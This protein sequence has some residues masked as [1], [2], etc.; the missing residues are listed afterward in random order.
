MARRR[1]AAASTAASAA[2]PAISTSVTH[3]ASPV[4]FKR[5][6]I[7][8]AF[9]R[10]ACSTLNTTS[11]VVSPLEFTRS[12]TASSIAAPGY[13]AATPS[14]SARAA[15]YFSSPTKVL[16]ER[17]VYTEAESSNM[18]SDS[19]MAASASATAHTISPMRFLRRAAASL[20]E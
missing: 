20:G 10:T 8:Q 16:G 2:Q 12:V 9:T 18:G 13:P 5:E 6:S 11:E 4:P 3:S 14:T 7:C 15:A 1:L 19:R 17:L